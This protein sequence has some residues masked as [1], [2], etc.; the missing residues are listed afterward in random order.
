MEESKKKYWR[1]YFN[2]KRNVNTK[3]LQ[4]NVGRTENGISIDKDTWNKTIQ[5][6]ND[7]LKINSTQTVVELACGNGQVIGNLS[8]NCKTAI[9]VDFSK[10]LLKQ[11]ELTY[12]KKVNPIFN[13]IME[14]SFNDESLEI[15]IIYNSIQYFSP[16]ETV[17]IVKKILHWLKSGGKILIG[18]VPDQLMKWKYI[19]KPEYRKDYLQRVLTDNP[20]IGY[21]FHSD[22]FVAM[23]DFFENCS[24]KILK[25][26]NYQI[27]SHFRYDVLITKK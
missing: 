4:K 10:D 18:G 17:L 7:T 5:Y 20:K 22:F 13:D 15:V 16:K 1:N 14:V 21:W 25:T 27:N 19:N 12:G 8:D 3:D 11:M 26:P 6:I 9:G 2:S 24:V 23:Q